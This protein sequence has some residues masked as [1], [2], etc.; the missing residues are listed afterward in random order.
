M[1]AVK[2]TII[3]GKLIF[4]RLISRK[5]V[6]AG[7]KRKAKSEPTIE[8]VERVNRRNAERTL[9]IKLHHN[10]KPG[11]F[12]VALTYGGEAPTLEEADKAFKKFRDKLRRQC[13]RDGVEFKWIA[14]TEW[15]NKRV[16]HHIVLNKVLTEEEL[17][18]LWP[19]GQAHIRVLSKSGDWRKLGEYLIKETDKTFRDPD[20]PGRLR[21]SCSRNLTMPMVYREEIAV[22][23]VFEE[24]EPV[25]GYYIDKS[26]F[27]RGENPFTG[28]PYSEYVMIPIDD[29][30]TRKRFNRKRV[31]YREERYDKWIREHAER[32]L[33]IEL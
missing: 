2:E 13:K 18:D 4:E 3:A 27:Y 22:S 12:F 33:E 11:D 23:E 5:A 1:A 19:Y 14:V 8:S 28:R 16:H 31:K 9:Q 21:Y 20:A 24:P 6:R 30:R 29:G 17:R 26:S 7:E 15:N 10:F 25:K 32:Q